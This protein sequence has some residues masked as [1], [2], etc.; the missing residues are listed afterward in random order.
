MLN[1]DVD[2]YTKTLNHRKKVRKLQIYNLLKT[3]KILKSKYRLSG[4]PFFTFSLGGQ[5]APLP[6]VNYITVYDIL[7]LHGVNCPNSTATRYE[8]V[9]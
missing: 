8:M 5:F 4:G 3:K 7:Y 1:P 2:G 6:L 9:A